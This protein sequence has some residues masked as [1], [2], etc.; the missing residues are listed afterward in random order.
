MRIL[1]TGGAGGIGQAAVRILR[2]NGHKVAVADRVKPKDADCYV[3][4]DL[5]KPDNASII[6][7]EVELALGR[8][9]A[10]VL[11]AARYDAST[12]D[13]CTLEDFSEVI[14]VNLESPLALVKAWV[15][16]RGASRAKTTIVLIAS[17]AA[18]VGSRD[19]GYAASKSGLLGL[20]R[21]LALNLTDRGIRVFSVSPGV[22]DTP[23]SLAQGE[24]RR[25]RHVSRTLLN[26]MGQ[27]DEVGEIIR[28]LLE[29]APDYMSGSD[30]NV[31]NGI[32]W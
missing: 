20:S 2:E 3:C 23:M 4:C 16:R 19:P 5:G 15:A 22:V 28:W 30:I 6:V 32:F 7:E 25:D 29:S 24:S 27:P 11:G 10:L 31:S 17:A 8:I 18:H 26:R 21:S 9:D 1:V 14:R 13:T 12:F